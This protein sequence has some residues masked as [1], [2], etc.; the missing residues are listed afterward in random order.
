MV[1]AVRATVKAQRQRDRLPVMVS[2]PSTA[3]AEYAQVLRGGV[4][5]VVAELLLLVMMGGTMARRIPERRQ[6]VAQVCSQACLVLQLIV[7]TAEYNGKADR[8]TP[9][10]AVVR[11]RGDTT[12][13]MAGLAVVVQ[14]MLKTRLELLEEPIPAVAAVVVGVPVATRVALA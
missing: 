9:V 10:A 6:K 14:D 2:I 8:I 12:D 4:V 11:G 13:L 7:M 5:Q 1:E 3:P